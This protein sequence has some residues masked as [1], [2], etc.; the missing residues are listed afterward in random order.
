MNDNIQ[1]IILEFLLNIKII[2]LLLL[3]LKQTKYYYLIENIYLKN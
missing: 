3:T 1:C 2:H